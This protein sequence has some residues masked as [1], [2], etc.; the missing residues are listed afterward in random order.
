MNYKFAKQEQSSVDNY[1]TSS[2]ITFFSLQKDPYWYIRGNCIE[3]NIGIFGSLY[4]QVVS[5]QNYLFINETNNQEKRSLIN[6]YFYICSE[7]PFEKKYGLS[8]STSSIIKSIP[9][10][11]YIPEIRKINKELSY[12]ELYS[13][14]SEL[15]DQNLVFVNVFKPDAF[16]NF[17]SAVTLFPYTPEDL[18]YVDN[19]QMNNFIMNLSKYLSLHCNY[20][21]DRISKDTLTITILK[22]KLKDLFYLA[23]DSDDLH[24]V[25]FCHNKSLLCNK[26]VSTY[27]ENY[28]CKKC[29]QVSYFY[30]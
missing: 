21:F 7:D 16:E 2:E 11:Q 24:S 30:I 20:S 19:V 25:T 12:K 15:S 10:Y 26:I 18:D 29:C 9:I 3:K 1:F 14:I 13:S 17:I 8:T 28:L 5:L 6:K 22:Q 4:E 27:C 23:N